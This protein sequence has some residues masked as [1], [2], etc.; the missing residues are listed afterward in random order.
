MNISSVISVRPSAATIAILCA[1]SIV[2]S[3]TPLSPEARAQE[4][5]SQGIHVQTNYVNVLASV[6][7]PDGHPI[8]D[9]PKDAFQ[10]F[11]DGVSQEIDRFE[12]ET[13]QPLD[14]ALMVDSSLSTQK[15]LKFEAEAA[16]RFIRQVV[17]PGDNLSVFQ[18]SD[19][20]VQLSE[21]SSNVPAQ[22]AAAH[23]IYPGAGTAMYDALV[24][25]SHALE[26]LPTG[27]RRV[28][29]LVTDAG[30]TTS[31]WKFEDARRAAIA[32]EALIYS[33]VIR[34][35]PNESGRNTA[36]EHALI[37]ITDDTGGALYYLDSFDQLQAMFDRIDR[38]LRTQYLLGYYPRPT[39]PPGTYR[40]IELRVQGGGT[41]HYRKEYLTA[42]GSK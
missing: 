22:Q 11:E 12:A 21:F 14:L 28:I 30:E 20:V 1:A 26:H 15:D 2:A 24:L 3:G 13:N 4:R 18:F 41:L 34:P 8:P 25:G 40:H 9:L 16:A 29:V 35:V 23:R 17:R 7:A 10:I 38:E 36:G 5:N 32:S 42:K 39:P 6:L 33:I 37:T 31:A 19:Y 27:R